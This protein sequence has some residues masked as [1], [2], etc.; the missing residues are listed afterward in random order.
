MGVAAKD[1]A[2][3]VELFK[4]ELTRVR[5]RSG[6]Y[7][8]AG[9]AMNPMQTMGN[10]SSRWTGAGFRGAS[11]AREM[12]SNARA[13]TRNACVLGSLLFAAFVSPASKA[14]DQIINVDQGWSIQQKNTWYT[15]SQGSRLIPL[16]WLRALEQPESSGRFLDPAHIEK[17]RYLPNASSAPGALPVGFTIDV[18]SDQKLSAVTKL[19]WKKPQSDREPWAGMNCSA[20]HTAE[21]TFQGKRLRLEGGP[22]LAD[23][24]S[25]MIALNRALV[26]TRDDAQKWNRFAAVVLAGVDTPSNRAM[27]R[28]ELAKLIEWQLKLEDANSTPLEY[29]FARLDAFGHIF[30]KVLLR[31]DATGQ[32]KNPAD[33]P[34]SY[35]FL[36]NIGQQDKVQ[37]NG[38][39]P[40]V[41]LSPGLDIGA[42]ARNIG[43]VIGVFA[44]VTLKPFGPA[45]AGY[46]TSARVKNLVLL[47]QQVAALKPP[48]WPDAFPAIDADRWEA[49]MKIFMKAP[50]GCSSCHT[51]LRRDDLKTRVDVTMTRLIGAKSIGTDPWM[52]CNAYTY[53]ARSGVL[54]GTPKKFFVFSSLPLGE[55][56]PMTDLLGT[57]GIGSIWSRKNE[58][59]GDIR[60]AL[61]SNVFF[62]SKQG[63]ALLQ[64]DAFA[65]DLFQ[66]MM[67]GDKLAR[68][69]RCLSE[70]SPVLAYKGRPLTGVWATPPFL[71]NG[72]VPT[73]YDLLLPPSQRPSSFPVG[74]REFDPEKVGYVTD[75]SSDKYQTQRS[76]QEN[77]FVFRATGA[78]GKV[79]PGNS[80][81]GH[82]YGNA[83]LTDE[84]RWALV[85]YMKAA[86]GQRDGN[87]IIP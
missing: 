28:A 84:E 34:V 23:F 79:I 26:A 86:G 14:A 30:N 31:V 75:K 48:V 54:E 42:L 73:L 29:G 15:L 32:P 38:I 9:N 13:Q 17:F 24:Q 3:T 8:R 21:I 37:W 41:P 66:P 81:A 44:D 6:R 11:R 67:S 5:P 83:A 60:H 85:E 18:Q 1:S 39:S 49:G 46:T 65:I 33:A 77:S 70:D 59:I 62:D 55:T 2:L 76:R 82:D 35:P 4:R 51:P 19:R 50:D 16:G 69:K 25:F 57:T 80:N 20:C 56:A 68:L 74:T 64:P 71:H 45:I 7:F 72:S 12:R 52:A 53:Q 87:R 63:S 36:W 22:T 27:L 43:E 10:P 58:L 61:T 40:N 47:E 78:D